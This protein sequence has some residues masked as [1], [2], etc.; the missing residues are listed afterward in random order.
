M[1]GGREVKEGRREGRKKGRK[2]TGNKGFRPNISTK[3]HPM[4]KKERKEESEWKEG[5]EGEEGRTYEVKKGSEGR[6]S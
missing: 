3:M 6:N 2:E 5:K 1:K 4:L